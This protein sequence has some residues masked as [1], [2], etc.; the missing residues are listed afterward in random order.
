MNRI[1]PHIFLGYPDKI[2]GYLCL[3]PET[4]KIIVS[5]DVIFIEDDFSMSKRLKSTA[6]P[7]DDECSQHLIGSPN[8]NPIGLVQQNEITQSTTGNSHAIDLQ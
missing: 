7:I 4:D 2:N 5:R 1:T 3:N 6:D 8:L